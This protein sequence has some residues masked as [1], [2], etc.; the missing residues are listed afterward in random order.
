M[1]RAGGSVVVEFGVASALTDY[2]ELSLAYYHSNNADDG[3]VLGLA[4]DF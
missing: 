4:F 1:L 3:V 2:S